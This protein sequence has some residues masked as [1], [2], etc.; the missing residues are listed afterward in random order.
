MSNDIEPMT[1]D[2][3]ARER[4][5]DQAA[6]DIKEARGNLGGATPGERAIASALIALAEIG[7]APPVSGASDVGTVS[8]ADVLSEIE[9][10]RGDTLALYREWREGETS[11]EFDVNLINSMAILLG[12]IAEDDDDDDIDDADPDGL[13]ATGKRWGPSDGL[14]P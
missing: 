8:N 10:A 13:R 9:K 2:E 12:Y 14:N 4:A 1:P 11:G 3:M 6:N 5:L 7:M